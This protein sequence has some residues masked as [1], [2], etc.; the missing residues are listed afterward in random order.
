M[1]Q[2]LESINF[3]REGDEYS[4]VNL[5][6]YFPDSNIDSFLTNLIIKKYLEKNTNSS[7][8]FKYVGILA[9]GNVTNC[10][11]PKYYYKQDLNGSLK[12]KYFIEFKEILRVLNKYQKLKEYDL[13][14]F[15]VVTKDLAGSEFLLADTIIK[16]YIQSG[17]YVKE[18]S[19]LIID[20]EGVTN[21]DAT[22]NLIEPVFSKGRPIYTKVVS[23]NNFIEEEYV[24]T[25][26][27]K[28]I[29]DY[30][31]NKYGDL[32]DYDLKSDFD[33]HEQLSDIGEKNFLN[34]LIRKELNEVYIDRKIR[35][36]RILHD[37]ID[38]MYNQT[39]SGLI[40]Y[41]TC[42]YHAIWE[43]VCS[44]V[45]HNLRYNAIKEVWPKLET[46]FKSDDGKKDKDFM[47]IIPQP[48]WTRILPPGAKKVT[49]TLIPDII[50]IIDNPVK[51]SDGSFKDK[52]F[53]VLDPK[54]Y[55]LEIEYNANDDDLSVKKNPGVGDIT[56]QIL[57]E[58]V[59]KDKLRN[60]YDKLYNILL[61]PKLY[62][63]DKAG[64]EVFYNII[65][66][67]R[68]D[69][70]IFSK[71]TVWLAGLNPRVIYDSY[72]KNNLKGEQELVNIAKEIDVIS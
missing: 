38:K 52:I 60:Y 13:G 27:H 29:V 4:K 24:I 67:V 46:L 56:K 21:W 9:K 28:Y 33:S 68:F 32:L 50:S 30:C 25:Q 59:Y 10:V 18:Y 54:Y 72:L 19:E 34:S 11:F 26:L 65:G 14:E 31:I 49:G 55:N 35:L 47:D 44:N 40:V 3:L 51:A 53:F 20:G 48:E 43:K 66:K 39:D 1:K 2:N 58:H 6:I 64:Y 12:E 36:L 62:E 7:Y 15:E 8:S 70:K 69:L 41:G 16:D 57:Y 22:V 17:I 5:S 71:N 42:S 23:G 61:F 45:F 63:K 37:I